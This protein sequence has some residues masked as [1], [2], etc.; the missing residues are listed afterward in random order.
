MV[1]VKA[2]RTSLEFALSDFAGPDELA[3]LLRVIEVLDQ[4]PS[5]RP[6]DVHAG[7]RL[8]NA[9]LRCF[10]SALRGSPLPL[11]DVAT[12]NSYASD[13]PPVPVLRSDGGVSRTGIDPVPAA[14]AA[15]ARDA[16]DTIASDASRLRICQDE[17]CRRIFMDRSR[18]KR[19]RWCSM[20]RCGNRAKIAA[21]RR[22]H[23]SNE[24]D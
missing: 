12:L 11:H 8:R 10:E 7:R 23:A 20:Q 22:R 17:H 6:D 18:G 16:I 1:N 9:M 13:D 3:N 14:F 24:R 15:I 5:V 21:F 2:S 4:E 19:R